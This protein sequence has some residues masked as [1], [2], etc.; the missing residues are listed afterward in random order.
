MATKASKAG[1][2]PDPKNKALIRYWS[3]AAWVGDARPPEPPSRELAKISRDVTSI[4]VVLSLVV[5]GI[6]VFG[7]PITLH[8]R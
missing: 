6:L 1:W 3:G 2:Y 7:I 8:A 5:L 4:K